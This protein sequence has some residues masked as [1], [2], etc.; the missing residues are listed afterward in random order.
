MIIYRMEFN[1]TGGPK[2]GIMKSGGG[3]ALGSDGSL[4]NG[5]RVNSHLQFL[6]HELLC[7]LFA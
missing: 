4:E 3:K 2:H 1:Q 6:M 5:A 7:E